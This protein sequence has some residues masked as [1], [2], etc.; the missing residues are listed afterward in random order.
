MLLKEL[1]GWLPS[2]AKVDLVPDGTAR[3]AEGD[4]AVRFSRRRPL[5][6]ATRSL[7]VAMLDAAERQSLV[8]VR[9][10]GSA[11][12]RVG[13]FGSP[14]SPAFASRWCSARAILPPV[15]RD[16]RPLVD[17]ILEAIESY[18]PGVIVPAHDGTIEAL[19]RFR[20]EVEARTFL[21]RGIARTRRRGG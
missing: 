16:P 7:D 18:Q 21:R 20:G 12:L 15:A 8:C 3:P 13:A 10:W 14:S 11:G 2:V 19:R 9:S 1:Q 4:S 5:P 6:G 17:G